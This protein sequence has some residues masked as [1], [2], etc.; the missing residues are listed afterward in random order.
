MK[1]KKLPQDVMDDFSRMTRDRV[2]KALKSVLQLV[3][4]G[5]Q[6]TMLI[7]V[8]AALCA[9]EAAHEMHDTRGGDLAECWARVN[10]LISEAMC[11]RIQEAVDAYQA[12]YGARQ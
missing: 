9:H 6:R 3:D 4:D 7:M 10:I 2:V 11:P 1:R 8:G 12:K 5:E